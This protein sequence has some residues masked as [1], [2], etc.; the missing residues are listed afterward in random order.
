ME[1]SLSSLEGAKKVNANTSAILDNGAKIA[2]CVDE[3]VDINEKMQESSKNL[4]TQ[5]KELDE[6]I[7]TFKI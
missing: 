1:K 4:G 3:I 7:G 5:T 2:G 6:M